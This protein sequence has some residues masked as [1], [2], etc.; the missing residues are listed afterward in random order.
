M[1]PNISLIDAAARIAL[2]ALALGV[3]GL[4]PESGYWGLLGLAPVA[5]GAFRLC[6]FVPRPPRDRQGALQV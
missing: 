2:G 3:L 6:P 1:R 4:A 5:S